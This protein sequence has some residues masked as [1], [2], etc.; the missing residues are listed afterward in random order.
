[1]GNLDLDA[2]E[3]DLDQVA[4][5][6][7]EAV[8]HRADVIGIHRLGGVVARRLRHLGRGPHDLRWVF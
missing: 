4:R 3:P 8:D 5:A 6:A 2:V 1:M 7:G